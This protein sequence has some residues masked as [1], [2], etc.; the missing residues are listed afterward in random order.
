VASD[1]DSETD[2]GFERMDVDRGSNG[3]EETDPRRQETPQPLEDETESEEDKDV[4][5]NLPSQGKEDGPAP[6]NR[7]GLVT[8]SSPPP[9]RDLPFAREK[10]GESHPPLED[11]ENTGESDDDEL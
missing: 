8:P 10:D 2:E 1:S 5:F 11:P 7:P 3:D 4:D 6:S 9:R